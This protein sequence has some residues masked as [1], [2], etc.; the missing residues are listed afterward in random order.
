MKRLGV[1]L[2]VLCAVAAVL[3]VAR[4]SN[5]EHGYRVAVVFDTAKGIVP[6]Q[7]VKIAGDR[8]GAVTDVSLT[9]QRTARLELEVD[10]RFAPFRSDASCRILPEGLIAEN[11]VQCQPGRASAPLGSVGGLP[12]VP[13]SQTT[14]PVSLQDVLNTFAF[15]T[16][17]RIGM[18]IDELGIATSGRGTDLNDLLR[19]ANP[20]LQQ[21]RRVLA[22]L[23]RQRQDLRASVEQTD[24][25]L[26]SLAVRDRDV[27]RFVS[28]AA[29]L[30]RTTALHRDDLG[31][32]VRR[33]P[34]LLDAA[35]PTLRSLDAT[36]TDATPLLRRV[37]G[38]V[39]AA[40]QITRELPAFADAALPAVRSIAQI[41]P[42]ARSVLR[43]ARPAAGHLKNTV[44]PL[45]DAAQVLAPLLVSSRDTGAVEWVLRTVYSFATNFAMYDQ[46]SHLLT[47]NI[48]VVARCIAAEAAKAPAAA[49][50]HRYDA[51]GRGSVPVNLASCGPQLDFWEGRCGTSFP[52]LSSLPAR[53]QSPKRA[54]AHRP[55]APASNNPIAERPEPAPGVGQSKP[56]APVVPQITGSGIQELLDF[57]LKP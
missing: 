36:V 33:L 30:A 4:R 51:A 32:S 41:A 18:I 6:G 11:F 34:A 25:V 10:D 56:P 40:R 49:C 1:G 21:S 22:V 5:D 52:G 20:A 24:R 7:Q 9:P 53:R 19:R 43:D 42:R 57:L 37:R 16:S 39:P 13:V 17:R 2:L 45:R 28:E 35:R 44:G 47:F 27:R 55:D 3:L 48:G 38:A 8:V 29:D 15:P 54:A 23:D 31:E 12:T 26:A 46:V 14:V 50:S